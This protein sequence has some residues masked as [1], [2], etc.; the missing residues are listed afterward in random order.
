M[1]YRILYTPRS[2]G[3]L[4]LFITGGVWWITETDAFSSAETSRS[5]T[6]GAGSDDVALLGIGGIDSRTAFNEPHAI[7]LTNQTQTPVE[8]TIESR[9][10]H[11]S[12]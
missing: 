3:A 6:V 10:G 8:V 11:I 2:S 9:N 5:A 7:T 12:N 4:A 1:I